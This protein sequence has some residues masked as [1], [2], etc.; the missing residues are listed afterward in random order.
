LPVLAWLDSCAWIDLSRYGLRG[1]PLVSQIV[2]SGAD[3]ILLPGDRFL[4]GP[5]CGI[6]LGLRDLIDQIKSHPLMAAAS[7]DKL[8]LAALA[9]TLRLYD[10]VDLAERSIPL[11]SLMATP[12]DNLRQRAERLAPQINAT[13]VASVEIVASHVPL[14]ASAAVQHELPSISIAL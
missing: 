4:G 7:A 6:I 2:N 11:L 3:L 13:G 10:D 5:P 8:V 12:L 1:E 14:A 9:A